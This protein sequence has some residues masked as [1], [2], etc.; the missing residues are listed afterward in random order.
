M[1]H[2][3]RAYDIR[4]IWNKDIDP[5]IAQD[6]GRA[7]GSFVKDRKMGRICIGY[8]VR[9]SSK[10]MESSVVSG[11]LSTGIDVLSVGRC[12]FGTAMYAG[13]RESCDASCYVT[14]SHLTPEWNG[15]KIYYGDGV[16]FPEENIMAIRDIYLD[17]KFSSAG[18]DS[19]G[20]YESNEFRQAYT[21]FWKE[22]YERDISGGKRRKLGVDCG[23]GAMSLSAPWV[24]DAV[25]ADKREVNCVSD[26]F[27]RNRPSEPS[28]ENLGILKER[29]LGEGLEF[30]IAFD[31][32][33]DRSVVV[34]D[35]GRF[36]SSDTLGI[37]IARELVKEE[38]GGL[39]LANVESSM[40]VEDVLEKE[41]A[42]VKRIRVGHT[43]LTLEAK[44]HNA[45]FGIE[46]SG[47][48]IVPRHVLFD[49]AMVAPLELLRIL[50]AKDVSLSKLADDVPKYPSVSKAFECPDEE[51]FDVV[52]KLKEEFSDVY[53]QVNTMDGVRVDTDDGWVLIRCSN[54][55]PLIR[56]TVEGRNEKK[57]DSLCEEFS[58]EL[59]GAIE[60]S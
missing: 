5:R 40:A 57:M 26:P 56:M 20:K 37:I 48:M 21:D 3:F 19:V 41:G 25:G 51:K 58:A 23:G 44:Q 45:I 30:G 24:F 6:I 17:G 7:L 13:W 1:K 9:T 35:R 8:D 43:F 12:S 60:G 32:D 28:P 46:K 38:G 52:E 4:G 18:W 34:D 54:T 47:H 59:E 11:L 31:G 55:S 36:L 49:D 10:I 15:L 27:F 42:K 22:R 53:D 33:G 39:V 16:G 29:V 14:A 2:I 50:N